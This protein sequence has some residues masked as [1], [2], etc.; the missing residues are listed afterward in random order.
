MP[1]ARA[2]R[3]AFRSSRVSTLPCAYEQYKLPFTIVARSTASGT[4]SDGLGGRPRS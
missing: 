3:M 2:A 1:A 4:A